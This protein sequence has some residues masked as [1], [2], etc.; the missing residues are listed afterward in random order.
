MQKIRIGLVG[1]GWMGK[2]H[3]SA[4]LNAQMLFGPDYG[5][6]V[7]E[8]VADNNE[9]SAKEAQHK[10]GYKRYTT[11]WMELVTDP[12]VDVVDVATPNALHYE[13]AKAAL[14]NGKHVYCEKPLSISAAESEELAALAKAKGVVNYV[15]FN[16]VMN[17]NNMG[18]VSSVFYHYS[19]VLFVNFFCNFFGHF[20]IRVVFLS[21][22]RSKYGDARTNFSHCFVTIHKL[23]HH[24]KN[25]P[26][27]IGLHFV[28]VF[29]FKGALNFF[30]NFLCHKILIF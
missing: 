12:N 28:P 23:A 21:S 14:E 16:N 17:G 15:G 19:S 24:F 29:L 27:V 3:S 18:F 9:A 5:V 20:V 30:V 6:A 13:V 11:N 8:M 26:R 1:A 22:S 25:G 2:A 7:F 4:L 10:L